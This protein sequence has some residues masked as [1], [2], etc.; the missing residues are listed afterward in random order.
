MSLFGKGAPRTTVLLLDIEN[1]SV[2]SGLVE[3]APGQAPRLFGESRVEVPLLDTRSAAQLLRAVEHAAS[4]ALLRASETSAR[5]RMAG[6]SHLPVQKAV[7]F[8]AAPWGVPNLSLGRPDF[9]GSLTATLAARIRALFGDAPVACHAHAS[10][11][12]HGLRV[13]YPEAH[14]AL[15]LSVNGE[16][17]ELLLVEAG[18]VAGHATVPVG[19]GTILRTL[20]SHAGHSIHEARSALRLGHHNEAS[21]AA[22][23]HFVGE[24]KDVAQ[25]LLRGRGASRV[26]VLA[27]E[28]AGEWVARTLSSATLAD[29]FPQG[30]VVR[31]MRAGQLAPYLAALGT[32]DTHLALGA[33]YTGAAHGR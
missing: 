16:L 17:S 20:K 11:A 8:L 12:V 28:P 27:H 7:V 31:A 25:D 2:G 23:A 14:D 32:Q 21:R 30:G 33:L 4:E 5:M 3:L 24:F 10:A 6:H 1:G 29:L 15:V 9:E 13:L 22:A 26:F 18:H 19:L